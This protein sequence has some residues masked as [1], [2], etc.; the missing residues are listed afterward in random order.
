MHIPLESLCI[1]HLPLVPPDSALSRSESDMVSV[2]TKTFLMTVCMAFCAAGERQNTVTLLSGMQAVNV[3]DRDLQL[4]SDM[5]SMMA[6]DDDDQFESFAKEPSA[7]LGGNEM[8]AY[9]KD[10]AA[11]LS[12]ALGPRWDAQR[13]EQDANL[14]SQALLQG[15]NSP[16]RLGAI[17]RMMNMMKV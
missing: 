13:L 2:C 17:S 7:A 3:H 8:D 6:D 4:R 12:A 1:P 14:K 9:M 10:S 15:I 5:R 16:K 11:G